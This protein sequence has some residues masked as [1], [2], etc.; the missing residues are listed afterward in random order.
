MPSPEKIAE[1]FIK[2]CERALNKKLVYTF[3]GSVR[4]KKYVEKKSD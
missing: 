3:F 1:E 2:E 4:F